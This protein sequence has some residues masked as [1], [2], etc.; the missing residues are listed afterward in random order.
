[1]SELINDQ[2]KIIEFSELD[3][4]GY[5]KT[6]ITI[7][8][9]DGVHLGHQAIISQMVKQANS[10][11]N[12]LIVITFFPNPY[13]FFN[14]KIKSFY[15]STPKEKETL[16]L[17]LGVGHVLT[18]Q[19][20][21]AFAN[22]TPKEFLSELK[23]KLALETLVVGEDFALGKNRQG[24]IPVIREIGKELSFQLK[25]L[26]SVSL[27]NM[28][29]SSTK[30]R[31]C[32]DDGDVACAA[33]LLGRYYGI[34]GIVTHGSDRGSRIGLPTANIIHWPKKKLPAIGVYATH[35]NLRE[36]RYKGI[37]NVGIRPTFEEQTLPNVETHIFDF[38]D[39]IYGEEMRL[40]FIEKIRDEKKFSGVE[41]FLAQIEKDKAA[42]KRIFKD[43]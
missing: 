5:E 19:F 34:L 28:E 11:G 33:K 21:R 4:M 22:L 8:N 18:F 23:A 32:L 25:V 1:M 24:T 30:V 10:Q 6:C 20:D 37:T 17:G 42:A 12:P 36:K 14:P 13:D 35:V 27:G 3:H 29:I 38:D 2:S 31:K 40:E 43:D 41:A 26:P 39:D 15:L 9:F 16:L 7:G